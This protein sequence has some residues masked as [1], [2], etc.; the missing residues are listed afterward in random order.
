MPSL[1]PPLEFPAPLASHGGAVHAMVF[2]RRYYL[3]EDESEG[4]YHPHSAAAIYSHSATG[5][6]A[7][8][9]A[10]SSAVGRSYDDSLPSLRDSQLR[11]HPFPSSSPH[12]TLHG[13]DAA[14][15][16]V[17]AATACPT[18]SLGLLASPP[19][20]PTPPPDAAFYVCPDSR[21]EFHW[22]AT[23]TE[24]HGLRGLWLAGGFECGHLCADAPLSL[25]P[26]MC[27]LTVSGT[28]R[29]AR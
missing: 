2:R 6:A 18:P 11:P 28:S 27:T 22:S 21:E 3:D 24:P 26:L 10:S 9:A 5:T 20:R 15:A 14:A 12:Q 8:P 7:V 17:E 23:S 25:L 29:S 1:H 4:G 16:V 19:P 13:C